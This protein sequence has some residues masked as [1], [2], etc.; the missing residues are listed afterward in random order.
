MTL[1][2]IGHGR[3]TLG[4]LVEALQSE[5]IGSVADVRRFPRSRANPQFN[6]DELPE[7]LVADGIRYKHWT[8]LGGRRR[9]LGA[10]SPNTA[11][12]NAAFRG[13]ADYMME[14]AFWSALDSLLGEARLTPTALMCSET[15]WWRCHRRLIADAAVAR[16]VPVLH[17]M[18]PG[19]VAKH[20]LSPPARIIGNYVRYAS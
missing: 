17:I 11:W 14:E 20:L 18:K 15:L 13:F 12:Q 9:G 1:Y 10:S 8:S 3:R 7:K 19:V 4:E 6:S 5:Q 2:T 16:G